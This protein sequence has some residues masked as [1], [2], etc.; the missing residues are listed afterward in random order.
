MTRI[1][2]VG[3]GLAGLTV[4]EALLTRH[5]HDIDLTVFERQP[6]AGGLVRSERLDGF[7]VEH[8][9]SG[10]LDTAP[11]TL[12]LIERLGLTGRLLQCRDEARRRY[13]YRAGRLRRLPSSPFTLLTSGV[14]TPAGAL[15]ALAE[16][17]VRRAPSGGD[18]TIHAFVARRFGLNA[19]DV[20]ADAVSSG[21]FGGDARLLSLRS[22]F[23]DLRVMEDE[24][25]SVVRALLARRRTAARSGGPRSGRLTSF[26]EGLGE[27]VTALSERLGARLRL[28]TPV[29]RVTRT[30]D[31][32][33]LAVG[34]GASVTADAVVMTCDLLAAR[35]LLE[36][37]RDLLAALAAIP[38]APIVTIA[39]GYP[40]S[41]LARPL[42]GFGLLAPRSAGVRLLGVL[43]E[44]SVFPHRA[45]PDHVLLRVMVGGATDPDAVSVDDERLLARVRAELRT[46]MGLGAR[47]VFA[48]V[49]RHR[50]GLP[51]FVVG[52]AGQLERI[53][54][55]LARTPGLHLGGHGLR[56]VGVNALIED[57]GRLAD[58]IAVR[59]RSPQPA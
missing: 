20:L 28:Q 7:L 23:P 59:V 12:A 16:P 37:E 14:L 48:R 43:W 33:Q 10:F 9:P 51:Q 47:P 26:P 32:Y 42:D 13:V 58:T 31:G 15:R 25:G 55:A 54:R 1:A 11:A 36:S 41:S 46:T 8:G 39:L 44:S 57:A 40:V 4:A 30:A 22:C 50:P 35:R 5:G 6:R 2:V 56:G 49:V 34:G 38:S 3:G 29:E 18:E 17:L 24:H 21:V 27:L 53:D 52:H 45:P 19:A